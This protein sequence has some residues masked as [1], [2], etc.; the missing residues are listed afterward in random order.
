MMCLITYIKNDYSIPLENLHNAIKEN[1]IAYWHH[2]DNTWIIRTNKKIPEIHNNLVRH[3]SA[4]DR[5]LIIEIKANYQGWLIPRAWDWLRTQFHK[6]SS[7][8]DF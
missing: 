7:F 2:L 3:I 8:F 6:E 5:I 1:S 4:N